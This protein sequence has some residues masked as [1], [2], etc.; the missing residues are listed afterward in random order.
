[1]AINTDMVR[2]AEICLRPLDTKENKPMR[3]IGLV[4]RPSYQRLNTLDL[5][6][7]SFASALTK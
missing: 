4:W 1:M 7:K 3:E 2:H 6:A 5:L